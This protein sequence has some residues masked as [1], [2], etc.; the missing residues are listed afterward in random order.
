MGSPVVGAEHLFLGML[1]DGGWPLCALSGL[2]DLGSAE[3]AVLGILNGPD[4]LPPP[5]PGLP[6]GD[7]LVHLWGFD[8][9]ETRV[10][11]SPRHAGPSALPV[12]RRDTGRLGWCRT[13]RID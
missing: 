7:S 13:G 8:V 3:A 6:V 10:R 11:H 9:K 2:V 12:A 4:Y 1:H 5:P